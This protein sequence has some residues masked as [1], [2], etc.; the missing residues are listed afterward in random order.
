MVRSGLGRETGW[1]KV[2]SGVLL[3]ATLISDE[4]AQPPIHPYPP[5][6]RLHT[7]RYYLF[8]P[9]LATTPTLIESLSA[10]LISSASPSPSASSHPDASPTHSS[11]DTDMATALAVAGV[12]DK[13]ESIDGEDYGTETET[14]GEGKGRRP[15]HQCIDIHVDFDVSLHIST[16]PPPQKKPS[17]PSFKKTKL[18]YKTLG[19]E[20]AYSPNIH[21]TC[22]LINDFSLNNFLPKSALQHKED[23]PPHPNNPNDL[24]K[25]QRR[26]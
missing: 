10:L 13:G 17:K 21:H 15:R 26:W 8:L 6:L 18:Y 19:S 4:L 9:I 11:M 14:E 25:L 2:H 16:H 5:R 22:F 1:S 23:P 20:D 3:T 7:R 12:R 24:C